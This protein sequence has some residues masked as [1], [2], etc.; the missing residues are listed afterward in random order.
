MDDRRTR[1]G[2]TAFWTACLMAA[3]QLTLLD[4]MGVAAETLGDSTGQFKEL[5]ELG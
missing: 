2:L 1:R 3:V 4:K 5:S